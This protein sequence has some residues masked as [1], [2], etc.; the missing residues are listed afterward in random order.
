MNLD[1]T[2]SVSLLTA[3]SANTETI[4]V[5]QNDLTGLVWTIKELNTQITRDHDQVWGQIK[6]VHSLLS[7]LNDNNEY[8]CDRCHD[9]L[10]MI[11]G[12]IF[13]FAITITVLLAGLK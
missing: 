8:Y 3:I 12:L 4:A 7:E 1:D 10:V 2:N 13:I 6:E 9:L 11:A 5:L